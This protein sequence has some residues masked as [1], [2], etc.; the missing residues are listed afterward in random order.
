MVFRTVDKDIRNQP[1]Q[2]QL[3]RKQT[4]D[5]ASLLLRKQLKGMLNIVF[6][7]C[8]VRMMVTRV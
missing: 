8:A 5:Q 3:T 1:I 7:S 6:V 4:M 2:L